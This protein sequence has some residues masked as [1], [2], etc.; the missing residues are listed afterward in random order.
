MTRHI[1]TFI[2][3]F[4][5]IATLG[6]TGKDLLYSKI[7]LK[8]TYLDNKYEITGFQLRSDFSDT[9]ITRLK[10]PK[11]HVDTLLASLS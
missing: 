9:V 2:L 4:L 10:L 8:G 1:T 3:F 6:Q 7:Y 11:H 5:T